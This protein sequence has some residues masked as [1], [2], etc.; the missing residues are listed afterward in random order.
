MGGGR[1]QLAELAGGGSVSDKF[2]DRELCVCGIT[3]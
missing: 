3:P 1:T 2:V